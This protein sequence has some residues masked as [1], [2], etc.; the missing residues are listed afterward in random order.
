MNFVAQG[1]NLGT[2]AFNRI[3]NCTGEFPN[4]GLIDQDR[5]GFHTPAFRLKN[6]E[7]QQVRQAL[8]EPFPS[9]FTVNGDPYTPQEKIPRNHL[10]ANNS[11][12]NGKGTVYICTLDQDMNSIFIVYDEKEFDPKVFERFIKIQSDLFH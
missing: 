3:K 8:I 11:K 5:I 1:L 7:I 2:E 4:C 12:P 6:D 10:W 9:V